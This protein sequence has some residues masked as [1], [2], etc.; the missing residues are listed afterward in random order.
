MRKE[1][2]EQLQKEILKNLGDNWEVQQTKIKKVGG[3]R[4]GLVCKCQGDNYGTVIYPEDYKRLMESG[5]S[6]SDIGRYL[7]DEA[8]RK[9]DTF[10]NVPGTPEQFREGLFVQMVNKE[11]NE[12]MLK[13][14]VHLTTE[15]MAAVVRCKTA[16]NENGE[17]SSFIVTK[18]N[19]GLFQMTEGEIL[20]QAYKNTASQEF[21]VKGIEDTM[22]EIMSE[23]GM[24]EELAENLF[25]QE[26]EEPF[27]VMTN[28]DKVYGANA[29]ACPETLRKTY[30]ELGEPYYVLPSST[31][32]VLLVKESKGYDT[33]MMKQIV[34]DVNASVSKEDLLSFKIFRYDGRKLSEVKEN[35]QSISDVKE[36]MKN[37]FVR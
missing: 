10:P 34:N 22:R 35:V 9:R 11:A 23:Q 29:L 37:R 32:E 28:K 7:A 13:N 30:E 15:D 36:K 20:E 27:Y 2:I 4:D 3:D 17:I 24:P 12:E 19:A 33:D 26:M 8:A 25:P 21:E 14:T 5:E 6:M 18:D 1:E 31:H 16:A